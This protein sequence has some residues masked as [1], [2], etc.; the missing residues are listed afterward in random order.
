VQKRFRESDACTRCASATTGGAKLRARPGREEVERKGGGWEHRG[1]EECEVMA[2]Q[3][4]FSSGLRIA[5]KY[6]LGRKI[7]SGSFGDIYLG[8]L[9][10]Y[11]PSLFAARNELLCLT[12]ERS[13]GTNA[14]T[15]EE[16]GIKM[17][18]SRTRHPQLLYESKLYRIMQG[19]AF[20]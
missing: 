9:R 4:N 17:E 12:C 16:V 7:G 15:G 3:G 1:G 11:I 6:V 19:G 10:A 14:Q 18:N 13:A 8:A 2:T 20:P 5:N